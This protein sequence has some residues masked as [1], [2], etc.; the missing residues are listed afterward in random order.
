MGCVAKGFKRLFPKAG[1]RASKLVLLVLVLPLHGAAQQAPEPL[2]PSPI[3]RTDSAGTAQP[4]VSA[5][6]SL[7][8][9]VRGPGGIAIPGATVTITET[10]TGERKQTWTD[11]AGKF[12]LAG[13]K[14]GAYKLEVSLVGF[15]SDVRDSVSV[16]TGEPVQVSLTLRIARATQASS[17]APRA[18]TPGS[19]PAN[20]ETPPGGFPNRVRNSGMGDGMAMG[21]ETGGG[22]A[23]ASE[24][25]S[26]AQRAANL[27]FSEDAVAGGATQANNSSGEDEPAPTD[28]GAAAANSFLL[29]GSVSQAPTPGENHG[30]GFGRNRQFGDNQGGVP[31]FGPGSGGGG[32]S[33]GFGGGGG[34]RAQVNRVRGNIFESY[35]NSALNAL[36]F[37]LNV[38]GE[39]PEIPYYQEQFGVSIGG[40]LV[41][42]KIYHGQDK[43]SFFINYNLQRN[44]SPFDI[45]STDAHHA[46]ARGKFFPTWR[47][48]CG[49]GA[50]HLQSLSGII[51]GPLHVESDRSAHTVSQQYDSY[52]YDLR[53]SPGPVAVYP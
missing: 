25:G 18:R 29:S 46:S 16:T 7:T 47:V 8:G 53:P 35:G 40:P 6:G 14:P 26:G 19:H 12:S 42:P 37:P 48:K 3:A 41:I 38:A 2:Q 13:V 10:T 44:R 5:T 1:L 22:G 24:A 50:H 45:L 49:D 11:E 15:Q 33:G 20:A 32:G 9:L 39:T 36:P 21:D 43:T 17:E 28:T 31:G 51:D 27:R 23:P 34:R 30:R 52:R 4:P